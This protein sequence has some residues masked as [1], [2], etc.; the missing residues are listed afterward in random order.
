MSD[1]TEAFGERLIV[2]RFEHGRISQEAVAER[3]GIHRTQISM[4]ENGKRTPF[5]STFIRLAG[6]VDLSPAELL[7]PIRWVPAAKGEPGHFVL[8]EEKP[9]SKAPANAFPQQKRF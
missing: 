8:I 5:L 7:G 1:L 6:A 4:Y 9:M 2:A 3:A